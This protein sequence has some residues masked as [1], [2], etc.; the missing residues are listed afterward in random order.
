MSIEN[1][2]S[3]FKELKECLFENAEDF[4][5]TEDYIDKFVSLKDLSDNRFDKYKLKGK[6]RFNEVYN[7]FV[8]LLIEKIKNLPIK[9]KTQIAT[10]MA[11]NYIEIII[12][13]KLKNEIK[14]ALDSRNLH[15]DVSNILDKY[16]KNKKAYQDSVKEIVISKIV[17]A[18]KTEKGIKNLMFETSGELFKIS[19][20][21]K[22]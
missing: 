9:Y 15:D 5:E 14:K 6:V 4:F 1:N 16:S 8:E 2:D 12:R 22:I 11:E 3:L 20:K 18:L 10:D 13:N 19:Q 17:I 21:L 7:D